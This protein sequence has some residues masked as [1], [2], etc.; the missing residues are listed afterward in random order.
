VLCKHEV[1]GSIPSGST[2]WLAPRLIAE[3][4][5]PS[6]TSFAGNIHRAMRVD[7]V[8]GG[9]QDIVKRKHIR[10]IPDLRREAFG[11]LSERSGQDHA[12][13]PWAGLTALSPDMFEAITG[14]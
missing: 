10:M 7:E 2:I 3:E 11:L 13:Q 9:F 5:A 14:L 4:A 12:H 1:V 6:K 8:A